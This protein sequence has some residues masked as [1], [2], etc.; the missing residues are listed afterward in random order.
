MN[1]KTKTGFDILK[2]A[3]CLGILGDLLLRQTPWGL[4]VLLFNLAF[5]GALALLLWSRKPEYLTKQT[6][7]LM[8]AQVFFAA[9]FVWRDSI[10]LRIADSFSI[11]A[12]L[13]V[14]FVPKLRVPARV[15]GAFHYAVG[16][17]WSSLNAWIGTVPLLTMDIEWKDGNRSAWARHAIAV[18]RGLLIVAP[19]FFVF[20]ALFMAADTTYQGIVQRV[21]DIAP[22][23]VFSHGILIVLFSWLSAGYLR[24]IMLGNEAKSTV[25]E[26]TPQPDSVS[27][28]DQVRQESGEHPVTLPGS[29]S[30][31]E[32][33]NISDPPDKQADSANKEDQKSEDKK[34]NWAN[35][36]NTLLPNA[37]TL[38]T[39]EIGVILGAI[40]LLFLSFV[41]VQLPYLFGGMELVQNTPDFKLA[42]YA[43]RGFG[44]LVTVSALVL[45]VLLVTHWLIRRGNPATERLFR[46]LAGV[47]IVLLFV[48][49]ASAVQ[50]LVLL[51]GN[52]GY[53]LTT[54]RLY[55]MIF[56]IWVAIVF[57]WFA[58][59]V[60][61][62]QRQY[63]AWGAL[64]S[65]FFVLAATHVLNPDD[66][67]VRT[68]IHLM[69]QG[70]EF[71]AGYNATL[72][73][74]ATPA[75]FE[76]FPALSEQDQQ[77][78]LRQYVGIHC[79]HSGD[80]DLRSF[81]ISRRRANKIFEVDQEV[82]STYGGCAASD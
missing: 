47:Q 28:I 31:L 59:T 61:R 30:I 44:E 56:M 14:L 72:S 35:I 58:V 29:L 39:V 25:D 12:I 1:A 3:L 11:L 40:N 49:M 10:E 77:K 20:F 27:K 48:I 23:E 34:W 16:F 64:W 22:E 45:P 46:V 51:T 18:F 75:L 38:G 69:Q 8:A 5:V 42:E 52:L 63:F 21:F 55:P 62:G 36:E 37:F 32:H 19:I 26:T 41:L 2:L 73:D 76:A 9:M 71:D 50:R 78:V 74:D 4:N 67:I 66:F 82:I 80:R 43:R 70:R 7:A 13:S 24:G 54:I 60:M 53:G 79:R 81:N 6:I 17:L 33:I 68:N 15:A 65:A 57:V